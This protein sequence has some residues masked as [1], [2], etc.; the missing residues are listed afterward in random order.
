MILEGTVEGEVHSRSPR[1]IEVGRLEVLDLEAGAFFGGGQGEA[2]LEERSR[3]ALHNRPGLSPFPED[4][5]AD[6]VVSRFEVRSMHHHPVFP[7]I[8]LPTVKVPHPAPVPLVGTI[9]GPPPRGQRSR[10]HLV[11]VFIGAGNRIPQLEVPREGGDSIRGCPSE[12]LQV[13][14]QRQGVL[15]RLALLNELIKP[16]E[17]ALQTRL[18]RL[19]LSG[20]NEA[21]RLLVMHDRTGGP[22]REECHCLFHRLRRPSG[23][24]QHLHHLRPH[25]PDFGILRGKGDGPVTGPSHRLLPVGLQDRVE[26]GRHA[27]LLA[28]REAGE[29]AAIIGGQAHRLPQFRN[30]VRGAETREQLLRARLRAGRDRSGLWIFEEPASPGEP[31]RVGGQLRVFVEDAFPKGGKL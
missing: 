16:T 4:P 12:L 28:E 9:P 11:E 26:V 27:G 25:G 1:A 23:P 10:H 6:R 21:Q 22:G 5:R 29:G 8:R 31:V 13:S 14:G 19:A 30:A 17:D 24:S 15:R 2:T 3:H 20:C 18:R 7:Q